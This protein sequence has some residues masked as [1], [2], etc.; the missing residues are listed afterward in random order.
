MKKIVTFIALFMLLMTFTKKAD[1]VAIDWVFSPDANVIAFGVTVLNGV[2]EIGSLEGGTQPAGIYGAGFS[3]TG[4]QGGVIFDADLYTWDSY[5]A[6]TGDGTG[7]WDAFVVTVSTDDYYWNLPH[8]DPV[9]S[10]E[11]TWVW[12][13]TQF[14]DGV[15]EN[16]TTAP[17]DTDMVILTPGVP[18][19]FYVSLVL[20]TT[21]TPDV[22]DNYPS[23]GSFHVEAVPE[24]GTLLLLGSGLLA[25]G[26]FRMRRS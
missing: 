20:D 12:G 10:S 8:S 22:D 7:Y 15:L 25:L 6:L 26:L 1:A 13:G 24:P 19:T 5:N 14:G 16:Y 3:Y 17:G 4:N 18:T 2:V 21:T 23:W 9:P 11:S